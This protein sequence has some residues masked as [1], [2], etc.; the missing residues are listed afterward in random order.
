MHAGGDDRQARAKYFTTVVI[1]MS[2][3]TRRL[4]E[5]ARKA[6]LDPPTAH[7]HAFAAQQFC[8]PSAF[9]QASV[10]PYD[11]VPGQ[12]L[13]SRRQHQADKARRRRIDVAIGP[14]ESL[15]DRPYRVDDPRPAQLH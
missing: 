9:G 11:P 13:P 8:L 3:T 2:N 15:G 10:G 6:E 4:A 1:A 14:H 12:V 5:H 7:R